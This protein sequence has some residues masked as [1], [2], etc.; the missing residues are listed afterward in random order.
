MNPIYKFELSINGGEAQRVFP[1]WADALALDYTHEQGEQFFRA[2]LSG[3]VT[4]LGP[5]YGLIA[6]AVFDAEFVLQIYISYDGGGTWEAYWAGA[7]WKTDCTFD[8]D[9]GTVEVTPKARDKY[10]AVLAGMDK[11]FDLIKLAPECVPVQ[12]DKRPMIQV[13]IAGQ[14]VISCFLAGTYWEQECKAVTNATT[15][16]NTYHF[17]ASRSEMIGVVSGTMSPQLPDVFHGENPGPSGSFN[18][19]NGDWRFHYSWISN[20]QTWTIIQISTNTVMWQYQ[21]YTVI[22]NWPSSITL[23]PQNGATGAVTIDLSIT[24]VWERLVC[25]VDTIAGNPTYDIPVNDITPNN[26]NYSKVIEYNFPDTVAFNSRLSAVPTEWGIYQPG[27]YY[28]SPYFFGQEFFPVGRNAWG[29]LSVWFTYY[30]FDWLIEEQGRKAYTLKDAYPLGSVISVLLG[31]IAPGV[32]HAETTDYSLFLYGTNPITAINQRLFVTPKSNIKTAGYDQPAQKAPVTL[33]EVLDM[34]RDC[35]RAYWFIDSAG[36]FRIE[37][38]SYFM[39]GGS[40]GTNVIGLDLTARIETRNGKAW[41]FGRDKWDFDK[42]EMAARYQFGWMDDVTQLFE[43]YPIDIVSRFVEQGNIQNISITNFTSDIDYILLNP[44]AIA[45]DGFV[46]MSAKLEGGAYV[47][48]YVN[49]N[50]DGN[51]HI[52]QNAWVAFVFLQRYYSYDMPAP[53]YEINGEAYTA[54]GVK[55]LRRQSLKFPALRE[56]DLQKLV[57][58][59]IGLG[60]IEKMSVTLS[61]R[62]ADATLKFDLV[63]SNE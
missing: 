46:L 32:T 22:P 13:Y 44:D 34:L 5:D 47:L 31:Q 56:P 14:T 21:H 60:M 35:F 49:F 61:S 19:D 39:N 27:Q 12:F 16:I 51:D 9:A 62:T 55:K 28:T 33:R 57:K 52:L 41:S 43:G 38:I 24:T 37:H 20:T 3:G 2:A 42:P 50:A 54:D 15:L 58:T 8:A 7:F 29:R 59:G 48:P 4:F 11:E 53:E 45:S 26:R 1:V 36:R 25:D 30:L 63:E 40:Y 6:G 17:A 10:D 23:T 18:F